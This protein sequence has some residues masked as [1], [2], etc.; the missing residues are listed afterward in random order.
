[1]K[2]KP[3]FLFTMASLA[4]AGALFTGRFAMLSGQ[5]GNAGQLM[6]G[7]GGFLNIPQGLLAGQKQAD[8]AAQE[9]AA[10]EEAQRQKAIADMKEARAKAEAARR[11]AGDFTP[12][13]E[14]VVAGADNRLCALI[15]SE[16]VQEGER[17][18]GYRV[19]K[20]R[21]DAVEFEKGGKVWVQKIR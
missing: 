8:V 3:G 19:R 9:A 11:K 14:A 4:A 13:V 1:M 7:G 10:R 2:I 17:I 20:I 6:Q 18:E 16:L 12:A 5:L 21:E 15:G